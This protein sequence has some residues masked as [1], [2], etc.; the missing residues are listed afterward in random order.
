MIQNT[1]KTLCQQPPTPGWGASDHFHEC[2]RFS[3][4]MSVFLFGMRNVSFGENYDLCL[5]PSVV[6]E[7]KHSWRENV[8]MSPFPDAILSF[9]D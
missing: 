1:F 4:E 8:T 3:D 2:N 9:K 6:A 5:A 7:P